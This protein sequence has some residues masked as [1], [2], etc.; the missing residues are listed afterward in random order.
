LKL[1]RGF[2]GATLAALLAGAGL[3]SCGVVAGLD[4]DFRAAPDGGPSGDG[5]DGPDTGDAAPEGGL[6]GCAEATYPSPPGGAD[7][8][9]DVGPLTLAIHTVD[10][11]DMGTTPGYDLDATCT[12]IDD[13]GPTCVGRSSKTSLYCDAPGG[14]DNQFSTIVQ[15]VELPLGTG[16]FS[17]SAFSAET[18]AGNWTLIVEITGYNGLKD[19]P[20]VHVA[21]YPCAALGTTAL[22]NGTDSWPV[23]ASSVDTMGAPLYVADGA[24]VADGTL[25]AT[26]PSVPIT[27]AGAKSTI[28]LT[29]SGAV[30]TGKLVKANTDWRLVQGVLAARL[31]LA[32]LFDALSSYRD[33]TGMPL[34]TNEGFLYPTA[35]TSICTDADLTLDGTA[36]K[37]APCDAISFGMGF[38][39][40]PA[41]KGPVVPVP[42]SEPGCPAATDPAND[43]CGT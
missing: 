19:D 16:T 23:I 36:P 27:L 18:T 6:P 1:T 43:S 31:G 42:Q 38:T 26:V 29:L 20:E 34:C 21:L 13:A 35:K 9:I 28:T 22:W 24:Y 7:D 40:D 5:G 32:S 8:G 12:C 14:V 30:L 33:G 10:L 11:G 3:A 2:L 4:G 37:S 15:L 25:V 41:V 39:A 17:S